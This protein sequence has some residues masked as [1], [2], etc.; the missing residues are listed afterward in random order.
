MCP[1]RQTRPG[2]HTNGELPAEPRV[3]IRTFVGE[4]MPDVLEGVRSALGA[5]AVILKTRM[6][7]HKGRRVVEL[8]AAFDELTGDCAPEAAD[9]D[10]QAW[11]FMTAELD[12]T[13]RQLH[14]I[15][16][17]DALERWLNEA[18]F[19]P[20]VMP[21]LRRAAFGAG[22]RMA[23]ATRLLVSR[24]RSSHGLLPL[25]DTRRRIAI[26]GPSGSGKSTTLVK[27]A[28]QAASTWRRDIVLVNLD[29]Y[30]PG[31]EEYLAQVGDTLRIP[32]LSER[33]H[34]VQSGLTDAGGLV[35]I[36]TDARLWSSD[37]GA[38]AVRTTLDRIQPDTVALVLPATWRSTDLLDAYRRYA[39]C[40]PTHLVFTGL[41]LTLRYGA[42]LSVA[43]L[44]ELPVACVLTSGR[45]ETG[46]R[47]FRIEALLQ[48]MQSIHREVGP[49]KESSRG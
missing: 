23:A 37:P 48:Q 13:R 46:T 44:S 39:V 41:D 30:R 15:Q 4:S 25:P 28:A 42:L 35:L 47:T 18:D 36:D 34:Q 12:A 45:F 29:S 33:A 21:D 2:L 6:R 31:A 14:R 49:T 5:G 19:H 9:I 1:A 3:L 11:S 10:R 7:T 38:R 20:E 40:Q 16:R 17:G 24:V 27:L 22:D 43:Y 8:T 32:V 26:I